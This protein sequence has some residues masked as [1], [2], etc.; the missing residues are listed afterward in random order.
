MAVMSENVREPLAEGL[1]AEAVDCGDATWPGEL[2]CGRRACNTL[3][4]VRQRHVSLTHAHTYT[5]TC[6]YATSAGFWKR[7]RV[8]ETASPK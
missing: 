8:H 3:D 6:V 1:S 2:G 7:E 5:H 4:T